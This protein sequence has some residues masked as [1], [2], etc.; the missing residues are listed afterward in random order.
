MNII[1]PPI[2]NLTLLRRANSTGVHLFD[3]T[4]KVINGLLTRAG[5]KCHLS[6]N[7]IYP[8]ALNIVVGAGMPGSPSI[9]ELRQ[10]SSPRNTIIFNTEQ[11]GSNSVLITKEYLKL[12]CDYVVWDYCN[13][14]IQ[15]LKSLTKTDICCHEFPIVPDNSLGI[16]LDDIPRPRHFDYDFAF[17]GAID[18]PRRQ[19]ILQHLHQNGLKIKLIHG[20]FGHTLS[21]Q[22]LDCKAVLNLHAYETGLFEIGRCLRPMA[23]GIPV[24]SEDSI[25]PHQVDWSTSGIIFD[26]KDNLLATCQSLISDSRMQQQS[27]RQMLSFVNHSRWPLVAAEIFNESL[28]DLQQR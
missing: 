28:N 27:Q 21:L 23:I 11:L 3:D 4:I 20:A 24:V 6:N 2:I 22:L 19:A 9:A 13:E 15:A 8:E 14:N 5:F 10:F 12:L 16:S 1:K 7:Q 25:F 17:Y 18:V 26:H